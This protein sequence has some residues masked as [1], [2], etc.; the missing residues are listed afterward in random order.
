MQGIN[1]RR[2][3]SFGRRTQHPE[4]RAP[5]DQARHPDA[6]N[7]GE[8]RVGGAMLGEVGRLPRQLRWCG[9]ALI[10]SGVLMVVAT[11]LH[12]SHETA[13]TIGN[14]LQP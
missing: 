2:L 7:V 14:P 1:Q 4:T 8:A 6:D 13:T 5:G 10:A 9:L 12:P 3:R 11:L